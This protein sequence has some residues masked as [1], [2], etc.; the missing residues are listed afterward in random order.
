MLTARG[1]SSL[2]LCDWAECGDAAPWTFGPS[3]NA[4]RDVDPTARDVDREY[5]RFEFGDELA[6]CARRSW[7]SRRTSAGC[8]TG[9]RQPAVFVKGTAQSRVDR[10][11][12]VGLARL[13]LDV[14][15]GRA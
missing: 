2:R 7:R 3:T 14:G 8:R 11:S 10:K 9:V 6:S 15:E 4:S 13:R 1:W 5:R 12:R